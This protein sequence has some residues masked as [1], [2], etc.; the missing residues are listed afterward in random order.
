MAI[1][2]HLPASR[3]AVRR[4]LGFTCEEWARNYSF[5]TKGVEGLLTTDGSHFAPGDVVQ[6]EATILPQGL[7]RNVNYYVTKVEFR[8]AKGWESFFIGLSATPGGPGIPIAKSG[9]NAGI[10]SQ[11]LVADPATDQLY[12][13]AHGL[14]ND[15]PV[16]FRTRGELPQPLK[17][18]GTYYVCVASAA[19]FSVSRERGGKPIDITTPGSGIHEMLIDWTWTLEAGQPAKAYAAGL[20]TT[21][22]AEADLWEITNDKLGI[23]IP[24]SQVPPDARK[25]AAPVQGVRLADGTWAASGPATIALYP[26]HAGEAGDHEP[27]REWPIEGCRRTDLRVGKGSA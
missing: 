9:T 19:R 13:R 8:G 5:D 14:A 10:T 20:K 17:A 24:M 7:S 21:L 15:T 22:L 18:G 26:R 25:A 23:R 12:V 2:T 16:I 3:L 1:R 11:A 4:G 27:S 6:V